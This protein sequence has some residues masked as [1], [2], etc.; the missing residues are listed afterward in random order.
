MSW[1]HCNDKACFPYQLIIV[2][3]VAKVVKL[4]EQEFDDSDCFNRMFDCS[5]TILLIFE[6]S[7][8]HSGVA[9][10]QLALGWVLK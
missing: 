3:G 7:G 5:K 9:R 2:S 8:K 6:L 1:I 10:L 4:I